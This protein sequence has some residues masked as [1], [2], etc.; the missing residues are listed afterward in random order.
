M[1][2]EIMNLEIIE[3]LSEFRNKLIYENRYFNTNDRFL[4]KLS[5]I[6]N[7]DLSSSNSVFVTTLQK[8]QILYRAR[9]IKDDENKYAY[10]KEMMK[11][12]GNELISI[13]DCENC[14]KA[15]QCVCE[16]PS[17]EIAHYFKDTAKLQ[18]KNKP[19]SS[20]DEL[21]FNGYGK[22]DS[23]KPPASMADYTLDM[24]AN[25][26]YIGYL[27]AAS[28]KYTAMLETRPNLNSFI[29][30]ANIEIQET[31]RIF[32]MTRLSDLPDNTDERFDLLLEL[33]NVFSTP[34]KG[35]LKDYLLSQVIS[36]YIKCYDIVP[37]FDGI[38]YMSSLNPK[39]K[40]YAIFD[41]SKY[42]PVSS[43]VYYINEVSLSAYSVTEDNY[44][45][46]TSDNP[47]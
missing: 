11:Q 20:S 30:V 14:E 16:K 17:I 41:E 8:N 47:L 29:S 18:F 45:K 38:C 37:K 19:L 3:M 4:N 7:N 5:E 27:Y 23:S 40:N 13:I 33:N 21:Y 25:P 32:D 34:V 46:I 35:D 31:T 36:E 1:E 10:A 28:D 15:N 12:S 43:D 9:V 44:N 2:G 24:R 39:G 6:I 22:E 42:T 26:K